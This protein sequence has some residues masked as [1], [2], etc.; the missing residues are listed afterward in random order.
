M[1]KYDIFGVLQEFENKTK[2]TETRKNRGFESG[3]K[4]EF[5]EDS[6]MGKKNFPR[7]LYRESRSMKRGSLG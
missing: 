4:F 2:E 6:L 1:K 7:W 5:E 3:E